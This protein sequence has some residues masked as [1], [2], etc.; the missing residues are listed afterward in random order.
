MSPRSGERPVDVHVTGLIGGG[1]KDQNLVAS[2]TR[3]GEIP[4]Y[5]PL[6]HQKAQA[7]FDLAQIRMPLACLSA[8]RW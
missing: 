5:E 6:A 2:I 7:D 1:D 3:R 4:L 8:K